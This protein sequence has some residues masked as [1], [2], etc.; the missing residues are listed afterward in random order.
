MNDG[1]VTGAELAGAL[2]IS[3]PDDSRAPVYLSTL[4][5]GIERFE[6]RTALLAA[7]QQRFDEI[8]TTS[9][10]EA[11][12]V[13]KPVF[14]EQMRAVIEQQARHLDDLSV[15]LD[16]LPDLRTALG[17]AL[18][19]SQPE[20][21]SGGSIDVYHEFLQT[22][23]TTSPAEFDLTP[24]AGTLSLVDAAMD[25]FV[26]SPALTNLHRQFLDARGQAL[27]ED[28]ARAR[29]QSITDAVSTVGTHYEQLLADYWTSERQNGVTV[30]E[31]FIRALAESFRQHL[32]AS[33]E[34]G[35]LGFVRKVGWGRIAAMIGWR[36]AWQSVTNSPTHRGN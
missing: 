9:I 8:G 10:V 21:D 26:H 32:L 34:N 3:D 20:L 31:F 14:A 28:H 13:E 27:S 7:L 22:I 25:D 24:V 23:A 16:S 15:Q 36:P 19:A 18:Q 35:L 29:Q 4:S 12:R 2:L 5:F 17:R 1:S 6:Q 33:R 11:E 30:L